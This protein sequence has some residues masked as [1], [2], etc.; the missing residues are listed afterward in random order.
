MA[1][2]DGIDSEPEDL[3][4]VPI[5]PERTSF[6]ARLQVTH[7]ISSRCGAGTMPAEYSLHD[8]ALCAM[9]VSRTPTPAGFLVPR[10]LQLKVRGLSSRGEIQSR[11]P[12]TRDGVA[13]GWRRIRGPPRRSLFSTQPT[14]I[15]H[16][17]A[18]PIRRHNAVPYPLRRHCPRSCQRRYRG[19][20]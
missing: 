3:R 12:N 5:C 19:P 11:D 4:R 8:G 13:H 10:N 16:S 20:R 18:T 9:Q 1:I 2:S 6:P 15:Q 14:S 17:P 7:L